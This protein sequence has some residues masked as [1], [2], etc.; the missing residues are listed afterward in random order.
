MLSA[1]AG[2]SLLAPKAFRI[3]TGPSPPEGRVT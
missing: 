3:P 1:A 2:E